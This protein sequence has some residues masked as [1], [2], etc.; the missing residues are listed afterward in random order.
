MEWWNKDIISIHSLRFRT[1]IQECWNMLKRFN[2]DILYSTTYYSIFNQTYSS[3]T[4]VEPSVD[5]LNRFN[6]PSFIIHHLFQTHN[7]PS[8]SLMFLPFRPLLLYVATENNFELHVV[9]IYIIYYLFCKGAFPTTL[10]I[11][12]SKHF[13]RWRHQLSIVREHLRTFMLAKLEVIVQRRNSTGKTPMVA[14]VWHS[15]PC[16]TTVYK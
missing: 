12:R 6:A 15:S 7:L 5:F 2:M 1:G 10:P 14:S 13:R 9:A 11:L 3:S 16:P 4:H 8:D